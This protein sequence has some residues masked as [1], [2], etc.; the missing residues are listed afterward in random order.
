ME[1]LIG[2]FIVGEASEDEAREVQDWCA[3]SPENQKYLD[4]SLLIYEQAQL[5][6][7][8]NFDTDLAWD[9][10]KSQINARKVKTRLFSPV[11]GIAAG[12]ILVLAFA[13]LFY[14]Q[15]TRPEQFQFVSENEVV[16]Q[17]LPDQTELSLNQNSTAKVE[18]NVR[19]KTG[20]I[21]VSGEVLVNIPETKKVE[22]IVKTENLLIR[23]IGTV[24]HVKSL[25][26]G[27]TVEVSVQEGEVQFYTETEAGVMLKAGEKGIYDK[28]KNEFFKAEADTN[29][30]SFKTRNFTFFERELKEVA[31]DLTAVYGK[32]II[33]DGNIAACKITVD[34]AN[35]D[36]DTILSIIAETMSLE[37][38]VEGEAIR[39]SGD[40]CF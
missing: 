26:G 23:D 7:D 25:P 18:Y 5:P 27:E 29:V 10:V 8:S 1:D 30:T 11:W 20:T 28:A 4:D 3:L 14:S 32:E 24:F 2:K 21:Q 35:E 19:K 33:L 9:K 15:N 36:L 40:G 37:V 17:I 34:F 6:D 16:T 38:T 39:L 22:W 12:I 13:F 31:A